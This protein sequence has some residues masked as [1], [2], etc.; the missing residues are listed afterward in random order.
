MLYLE[1][2]V[3]TQ[4]S[5][6][7]TDFPIFVVERGKGGSF[8][9]ILGHLKL[10]FHC[11]QKALSTPLLVDFRPTYGKQNSSLKRAKRRCCKEMP[12]SN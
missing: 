11:S 9:A 2:P 4:I 8:R 10:K 3:G 12:S 5:T 7:S 1:G 6:Y